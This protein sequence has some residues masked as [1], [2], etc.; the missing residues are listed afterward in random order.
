MSTESF[1]M[2]ATSR[3][4]TELE[5]MLSEFVPEITAATTLTVTVSIEVDNEPTL[6]PRHRRCSQ[7]EKP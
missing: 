2:P 5:E 4:V 7:K 1:T 3:F 6:T